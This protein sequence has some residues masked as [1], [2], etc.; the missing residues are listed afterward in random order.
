VSADEAHTEMPTMVD[1]AAA[2]A[3]GEL[4]ATALLERCIEVIEAHND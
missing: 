1:A 2:I 4:T 3:A